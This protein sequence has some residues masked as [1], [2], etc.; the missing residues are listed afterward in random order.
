MNKPARSG[1]IDA[2]RALACLAVV[3]HHAVPHLHAVAAPSL[4]AA[5]AA[6]GLHGWLGIPVFFV[7]SGYCISES[8]ARRANSPGAGALAFWLDRGLRIYP[9][10]WAALLLACVL[11]AA[12]TPFNGR[13]PAS[14]WPASLPAA[15]A[16]ISLT[17]SWFGE[18]TRLLVSWSLHYEIAFYLLIGATLLPGLRTPSRRLACIAGLTACVCLFPSLFAPTALRLWPYFACGCLVHF[19]LRSRLP[20]PAR[21]CCLAYP[22]AA[23][24]LRPELAQLAATIASLALVAIGLLEKKL[25][26]PPAALVKIGLASYSIYLVHVPL[27]SPFNN[28]LRR[29]IPADHPGQLAVVGAAAGLAVGAGLLFYRYVELYMEKKRRGSILSPASGPAHPPR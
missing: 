26:A 22:L 13:P 18:P 5:L 7:L 11:A 24:A 17:A 4:V 8:I 14:A 9:A 15:L 10:F 19:A 1:W 27:I 6:I 28:L 21:L 16:D 3:L 12:A 20:L 2:L 29:F 25:P 23:L